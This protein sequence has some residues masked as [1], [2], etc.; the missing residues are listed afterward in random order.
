[1]SEYRIRYKS[2][3]DGV[4]S[5]KYPVVWSPAYRR[6]VLKDG[7]D[8]RLKDVV[9]EVCNECSAAVLEMEVMPDHVHRLAEL[10]PPFG[11]ARPGK[12]IR[13]RSLRLL[14]QEVRPGHTRLP[15]LWT[16]SWFVSTVGGAPREVTEQYVAQ[17]KH[18]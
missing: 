2:R 5:C 3:K 12:A 7:V 18:V 14:S 10:D 8:V 11:I 16:H 4:Y 17:Q 15:S 6:D 1:M 9:S 13:V